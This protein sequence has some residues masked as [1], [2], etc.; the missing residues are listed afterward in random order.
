MN[1]V[2]PDKYK[3]YTVPQHMDAK[4]LEGCC[5]KEGENIYHIL[6]G[7]LLLK[8]VSMYTLSMSIYLC[9]YLQP[10]LVFMQI[11][12]DQTCITFF[13]TELHIPLRL[14]MPLP[15]RIQCSQSKFKQESRL[16]TQAIKTPFQ[17]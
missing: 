17:L 2:K 13:S 12:S 3:F 15:S 6:Y 16:K 9:G 4:R 14:H 7:I 1:G 8:P 11:D 5:W 10:G